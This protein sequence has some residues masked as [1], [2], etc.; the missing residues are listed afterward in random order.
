MAY[1]SFLYMEN[2]KVITIT[3][4]IAY[5]LHKLSHYPAISAKD[6]ITNCYLWSS[7]QPCDIKSILQQMVPRK[8]RVT[9]VGKEFESTTDHVEKWY[10]TPYSVHRVP[11]STL[12][13]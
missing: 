9:V 8:V 11:E 12:Q 6:V 4:D 10:G 3:E 7:F 2:R 5:Q 13:K 1:I